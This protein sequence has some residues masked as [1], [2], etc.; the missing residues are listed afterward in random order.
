MSIS[1]TRLGDQAPVLL[2]PGGAFQF[3]GKRHR[4]ALL[5]SPGGF[6]EWHSADAGFDEAGLSAFL[7][8]EEARG[9]DLLLLGTGPKSFLLPA[10]FAA[11]VE[12]RGLGLEA[13]DTGAACRTYNVLLAENRHFLAALLPI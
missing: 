12:R 13:M 4:G 3:G 8:M 7:D 11:Q 2:Y 10:A 5:I 9:C 6:Y 1:F